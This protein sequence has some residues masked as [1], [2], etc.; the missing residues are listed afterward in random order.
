M[1]WIVGVTLE[2]EESN[3]LE[4]QI[5]RPSGD[6]RYRKQHTILVPIASEKE[7]CVYEVAVDP[8]LP[9]QPGDVLGILQ[10]DGS[11]LELV[12]DDS[13]DSVFYYTE[14]T[15]Q[16]FIIDSENRVEIQRGLPLVTVEI[17]KVN[18]FP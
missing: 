5:W 12:Y 6:S 8:P 7:N 17:G 18:C 14:S 15:V 13:E 4:F 2:N 9:F 11:E 1:K 3:D 16:H 10:S